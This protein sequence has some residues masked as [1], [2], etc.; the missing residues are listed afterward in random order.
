MVTGIQVGFIDYIVHPLWETW[1][2]LVYPDCQDILD[3]LEDNRSWYQS[4]IPP[5]DN[6]VCSNSPSP[7]HKRVPSVGDTSNVDGVAMNARTPNTSV[8][9]GCRYAGVT[10]GGIFRHHSP[11]IH[12]NPCHTVPDIKEEQWIQASEGVSLIKLCTKRFLLQ[13]T[14]NNCECSLFQDKYI[15]NSSVIM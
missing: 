14:W 9:L 13:I 2:E 10:I 15:S 12:G 1:A 3:A 7:S 8:T 6:A 4:L 11:G 5:E